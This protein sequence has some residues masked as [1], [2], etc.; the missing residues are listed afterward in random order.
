MAD[1]YTP[2]GDSTYLLMTLFYMPTESGKLCDDH[3]IRVVWTL[4]CSLA[5]CFVGKKAADVTIGSRISLKLTE[6]PI[7]IGQEQQMVEFTYGYQLTGIDFGLQH[8]SGLT[9]SVSGSCKTEY[10]WLVSNVTGGERYYLWGDAAQSVIIP[11]NASDIRLAPRVSFRICQ[12][13]DSD[14]C[15]AL[16]QDFTTPIA[17]IVSSA[18]RGSVTAESDPWY[19][20]EPRPS[21]ALPEPPIPGVDFWMKLGRPILSCWQQDQWSYGGLSTYSVDRLDEL[22][23]LSLP[24]SLRS[25]LAA[26]LRLP[27]VV[28]L[29][30]ASGDSALRSRTTSPNGVIDAGKSSI[31]SDMRR[32]IIGAFVATRNV[33]VDAT[34]Y[35]KQDDYKNLLYGD[36]QRPAEGAGD[37]VIRDPN[38]Q[39]FNLGGI[40]ALAVV[41]AVLALTVEAISLV[42]QHGSSSTPKSERHGNEEGTTNAVHEPATPTAAQLGRATPTK[43]HGN[44]KKTNEVHKKTTPTAAQPGGAE[45][46]EGGWLI[47]SRV[48]LAPQLFRCSGERKMEDVE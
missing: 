28:S 43:G 24:E 7:V 12:S 47:R 40:I 18:R 14:T 2:A 23:G 19:L 41:M 34:M 36:N 25:V 22:P 33:L 35:G 37:F 10:D 9:L 16:S 3:N 32:L 42:V 6:T 39:T 31:E 46:T 45:V 13:P 21:D 15:T 29:G 20:T 4:T 5:L 8:A 30:T 11:H 26:A 44:E 27:M 17:V 48:L 38:I 1:I